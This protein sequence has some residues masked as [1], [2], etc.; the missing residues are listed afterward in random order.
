MRASVNV[1]TT[2]FCGR[3][4]GLSRQRS[5]LQIVGIATNNVKRIYLSSFYSL[6]PTKSTVMYLFLMST[7]LI[8]KAMYRCYYYSVLLCALSRRA[9]AAAGLPRE[10]TRVRTAVTR[11]LIADRCFWGFAAPTG[12]GNFPSF[13]FDSIADR[14]LD[15][16]RLYND[17]SIQSVFDVVLLKK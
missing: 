2:C 10:C 15:I 9:T 4:W 13:I 6:T 11:S 8:G 16:G 5:K 14:R 1:A 7:S 3:S 12:T 17:Q